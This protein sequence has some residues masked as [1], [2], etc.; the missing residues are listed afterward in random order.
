M[1][2]PDCFKEEDMRLFVSVNLTPEMKRCVKD[3]QTALKRE[4]YGGRYP[5]EENFHITLAF[6]GEFSD[7]PKVKAAL[8]KVS[9][10][11]FEISAGGI[12]HFGSIYYVR[13][14]SEKRLLDALSEK[15]KLELQKAG[16]PFDPKKFK[17]HITVGRDVECDA[18]PNS[19]GSAK[20]VV[21]EFSLK[22]S[23]FISGKRIY[24]SLITVQAN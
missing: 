6:I 5:S 10:S 20:M 4:S 9:F 7:L 18:T 13:V 23:E 8:G 17:A 15:V 21:S 19:L 1:L 16:V 3:H 12:G 2:P 14:N 22:K 11:P 24:K